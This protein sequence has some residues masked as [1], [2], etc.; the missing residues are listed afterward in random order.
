MKVELSER[1]K[2]ALKALAH[3]DRERIRTWFDYLARWGED[4][5]VK[6]HSVQLDVQGQAVY[7]FQ[8]STDVRIFYKV[9]KERET[10]YVLDVTKKDTILSSGSA[11]GRG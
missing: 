3:D 9:D 2:T 4:P 7:L 1:V 6:D 8:T 10:V 5:F 11:S